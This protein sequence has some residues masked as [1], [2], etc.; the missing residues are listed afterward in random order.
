MN[1]ESW[2][3]EAEQVLT[4]WGR[5]CRDDWRRHLGYTIPP[6]SRFYNLLNNKRT[7]APAINVAEAETANE[8]IIRLGLFDRFDDH[9]MI[10]S[11]FA[12]GRN[13]SFIATQIGCHR[14][15]VYRR[16]D[17]AKREFWKIYREI[18]SCTVRQKTA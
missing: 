10:I 3:Q 5:W 2:K 1:S 4:N 15:T 14:A 9:R 12:H 7:P 13:A 18:M 11:W 6:A 17:A 16:L 8:A